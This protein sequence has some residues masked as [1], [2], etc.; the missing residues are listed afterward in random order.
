[1]AVGSALVIWAGFVLP[2]LG[3]TL[4]IS[5]VSV[6]RTVSACAYWLVAMVV[7]ASV[8]KLWGLTAPPV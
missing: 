5:G 8:M 3:V 2:A 6:S 7:Q 1:M 4:L